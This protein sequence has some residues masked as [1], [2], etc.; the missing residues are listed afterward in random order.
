MAVF[1]RLESFEKLSTHYYAN[2]V[3]II[4]PWGRTPPRNNITLMLWSREMPFMP[5]V[6]SALHSVPQGECK[7]SKLRKMDIQVE[8]HCWRTNQ[9]P[10]KG[11][12]MFFSIPPSNLLIYVL[13][14]RRAFWDD[15][16][17]FKGP[18]PLMHKLLLEL[19]RLR[20]AICCAASSP[21]TLSRT[22]TYHKPW[23]I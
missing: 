21:M 22:T 14:P 9:W 8:N 15:M 12:R 13:Y 16:A 18:Q 17:P 7:Q 6:I 2:V 23:L 3:V 19:Q 20:D 11:E 4:F 1:I 5:I 10:L